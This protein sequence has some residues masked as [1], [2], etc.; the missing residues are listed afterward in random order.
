MAGVEGQ[1]AQE[2]LAS[3]SSERATNGT[4]YRRRGPAALDGEA[5]VPSLCGT[6]VCACLSALAVVKELALGALFG[7]ASLVP[8]FAPVSVIGRLLVLRHMLE[9]RR[10]HLPPDNPPHPQ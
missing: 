6:R 1:P 7:Q 8:K 3:G 2:G 5:C 9:I 10:T 4:R